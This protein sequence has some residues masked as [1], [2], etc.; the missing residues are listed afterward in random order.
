MKILLAVDSSA[1]SDLAIRAVAARP[2]PQSA[3]VEVLSVVDPFYSSETPALI[4]TV[5]QRAEE[6]VQAA[7]QQLRS[8]GIESRTQVL[9]G[10]AKG[11]IVEYARQSGSD[12]IVVGS[13][14][15]TTVRQFLHGSVARAVVRFAPCSVEVVRGDMGPGAMKILL[16]TDGS[17]YSEA[18]ARSIADR[19][20]PGATQ[21][22][23]LSVAD[24]HVRMSAIAKLPHFDRQAMERLEEEGM[25]RAQEAVVSAEKIII[26]GH[27]AMS[28]AVAVPSAA[29]KE[30]I[31]KEANDWGADL[32]V[33]GSHGR[34]GLTR[35]VLGSVS[36]AVATCALCSVEVIRLLR[37]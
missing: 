1:E 34:D 16:A 13:H 11:A 31:L 30:F 17:H 8:S 23:I 7:A 2:W 20:W 19:P 10:N 12:L 29:P 24:H 22:R 27:L 36:E 28:G 4:E 21:V 32:I 26:E 37:S 15:L 35:L 33:V 9:C 5:K 14:K 3:T 25:K 18:A 6:A